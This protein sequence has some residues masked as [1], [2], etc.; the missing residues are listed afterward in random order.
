MKL[1]TENHNY[2]N[3]DYKWCIVHLGGKEIGRCDVREDG[4][5]LRGGRKARPLEDVAM[6]MLKAAIADAKERRVQ[7]VADETTA[8]LQMQALKVAARGK[9]P[10]VKLTGRP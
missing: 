8:K 5:V 2:P 1:T 6:A 7:A 9:T 4:Y 3:P 10:N